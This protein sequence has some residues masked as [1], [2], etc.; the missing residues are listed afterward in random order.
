MHDAM[1]RDAYAYRFATRMQQA[2]RNFTRGVQYECVASW[3]RR[4]E[5]P[6]LAVIDA[7]IGRSL[8][9]IPAQQS[10]MM[11]RIQAAYRTDALHGG[12]VA[13]P[14]T[15]RVT[16]ICRIHGHPAGAYDLD[17]LS[18]Q[19]LLRILRMNGKKLCQF[20]SPMTDGC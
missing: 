9:Q 12:F 7:R 10:E 15:Q 8:R 13:N 20:N 16:G 3:R 5:Q 18:Y 17:R 6:E 14:A 19:A 11:A 4:F 2:A 1:G